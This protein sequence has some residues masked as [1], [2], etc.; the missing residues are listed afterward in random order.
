MTTEAYEA[1][2]TET[3][4][5]EVIEEIHAQE[6]R[7][8]VFRHESAG[9]QHGYG[10]NETEALSELRSRGKRY[11]E[12]FAH[13]KAIANWPRKKYGVFR[14]EGAVSTRV[15]SEGHTYDQAEAA[16]WAASL[17]TSYRNSKV[18][19]HQSAIN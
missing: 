17:N 11:F 10:S 14:R 9:V 16:Q 7:A 2:V 12:A 19:F 18:R 8:Y 1:G 3:E 15:E 4:F 5:N 13:A 6:Q